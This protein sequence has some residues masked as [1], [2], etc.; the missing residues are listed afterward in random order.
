MTGLLALGVGTV[1]LVRHGDSGAGR[2]RS[3]GGEIVAVQAVKAIRGTMTTTLQF[4]GR[5]AS[6][7]TIRVTPG[8]AGTVTGV[9]IAPG[10][11]VAAGTLLFTLSNPAVT[12]HAQIAAGNAQAA[13]ARLRQAEAGGSPGAVAQARAALALAQARQKSLSEPNPA[14]VQRQQAAVAQA[15]AQVSVAQQ[16]LQALQSGQAP[17][18]VA[19]QNAEQASGASATGPQTAAA[20]NLTLAEQA[21][22]QVQ[23]PTSPQSVA[24]ANAQQA[25]NAALGQEQT[26][27][28]V[29]YGQAAVAAAAAVLTTAEAEYTAAV[30][31]AQQAVAA[32]QVQAQASASSAGTQVSAAQASYQFAL[33]NAQHA[34]QTAQANLAAQQGVL[35]SL[36]TN[37]V[38]PAVMAEAA[39]AVLG[40][41]ARLQTV[42]QPNT[43]AT[44]AGFQAEAASA[45][46]NSSLAALQA[47][48]LR[49]LAPT[50]GTV[51]AMNPALSQV[52]ATVGAGS[53]LATIQSDVMQAEGPIPQRDIGQV[54]PGQPAAIYTSAAPST[55]IPASVVGVS[56]TGDLSNL[57]FLVTVAP[58]HPGGLA[59]GESAS[60]QLLT[61]QIEGATLVPSTALQT[62]SHGSFVYVLATG[63]STGAKVGAAPSSRASAPRAGDSTKGASRTTGASA[64]SGSQASRAAATAGNRGGSPGNGTVR[65]VAVRTG[66]TSGSWTQVLSGL[67]P[68]AVVLVPGTGSYLATG[69]RVAVTIIR[70]ARPPAFPVSV[71]GAAVSG[72]VIATTV[73]AG[74]GA[75]PAPARAVQGRKRGK[76]T[77][78][79]AGRGGRG[80]HAG[81][82]GGK[83][84]GGGKAARGGLGPRGAGKAAGFAGGGPSAGGALGGGVG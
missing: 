28:G 74:G 17:A 51:I 30:Q 67:K 75:S 15:E 77:G 10:Q 79:N 50:A 20:A 43:P 31:K 23:A 36:T 3:K 16:N 66:V 39:A 72:A 26:V 21:L 81:K 2:P 54:H 78:P 22:Q 52:G 71:A 40:A 41:Q 48:K 11:A 19:L 5:V 9:D 34:L 44:M 37:A 1:A 8:V 42:E 45:A 73:A 49:V 82:T 29:T 57:T 6:S 76:K 63:A 33:S 55:A 12:L 4:V 68:G 59:A 13:T 18:A 58:V 64:T 32:A 61:Q 70:V 62:G 65:V 80:K 47:A 56:P 60:V 27:S 69:D 35:A 38:T 14:L 83:G 53:V 46:A 24:I 25:Y 84:L 7:Y